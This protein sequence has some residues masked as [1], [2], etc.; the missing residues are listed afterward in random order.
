VGKKK[1]GGLSFVDPIE[2]TEA[3]LSKWVVHALDFR[4]SNL[5]ESFKIWLRQY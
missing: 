4:A 3:L 5:Q 2:A 1:M